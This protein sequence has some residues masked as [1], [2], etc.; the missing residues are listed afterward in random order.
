MI[1]KVQTLAANTSIFHDKSQGFLKCDFKLS[2]P[3]ACICPACVFDPL[4]R[5]NSLGHFNFYLFYFILST[6]YLHLKFIILKISGCHTCVI[7]TFQLYW[8]AFYIFC[9]FLIFFIY[10]SFF[11]V[12]S[13]SCWICLQINCLVLRFKVWYIFS[14]LCHQCICSGVKSSHFNYNTADKF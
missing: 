1:R 8:K 12:N 2:S 7:I 5:S 13:I 10:F 11:S 4:N 14:M 9:C 3:D 6:F